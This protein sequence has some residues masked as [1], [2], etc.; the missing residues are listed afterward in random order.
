LFD[1]SMKDFAAGAPAVRVAALL[2]CLIAIISYAFVVWRWYVGLV[3]DFD[4][5]MRKQAGN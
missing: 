4:M 5:T 1:N 2:G 3:R